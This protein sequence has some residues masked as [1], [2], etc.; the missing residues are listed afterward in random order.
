L[1]LAPSS[2][3]KLGNLIFNHHT[4]RVPAKSQWV[5]GE[6]AQRARC[7]RDRARPH[8]VRAFP[9][10]R[11]DRYGQPAHH[12]KDT[13]GRLW[14]C[15]SHRRRATGER[16]R[17]ALQPHESF[18]TQEHGLVLRRYQDLR[19]SARCPFAVSHHAW[20]FP[21]VPVEKNETNWVQWKVRDPSHPVDIDER[22]CVR[23]RWCDG[24]G[25]PGPAP[26]RVRGDSGSHE[27]KRT[28]FPDTPPAPPRRVPSRE[29]WRGSSGSP[30][31]VFPRLHLRATARGTTNLLLGPAAGA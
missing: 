20:R 16:P 13:S 17:F 10:W 6:P 28:P 30:L 11:P 14:W 19:S 31:H 7:C 22:V 24:R 21:Y 15:N 12:S 3:T 9:E 23:V 4:R 5:G 8:C 29:D 25:L 2:F 18:T 27:S 1:R 26:P